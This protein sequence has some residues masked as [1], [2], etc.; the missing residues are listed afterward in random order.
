MFGKKAG[1][2]DYVLEKES[3]VGRGSEAD[4]IT[5]YICFVEETERRYRSKTTG[6]RRADREQFVLE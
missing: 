4:P 5:E 6:R 2:W 3:P 1:P